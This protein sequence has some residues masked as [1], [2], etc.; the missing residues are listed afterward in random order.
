MP[1]L[2]GMPT[3]APSPYSQ[4][5][6]M[7]QQQTPDQRHNEMRN[8]L[9]KQIMGTPATS[10]AGGVGQMV[11]GAGMGLRNFMDKPENQFPTAPGGA[12]PSFGARIANVF[13]F[14]PKAGLF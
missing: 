5:A 3:G 7:G 8:Q 13:G 6:Y 1:G 11:A 4:Y 2:P 9:A 14:G 12:A 10:V